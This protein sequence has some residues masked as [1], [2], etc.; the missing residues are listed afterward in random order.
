[1]SGHRELPVTIGAWW[2]T[3]MAH[4]NC[5]LQP[6]WAILGTNPTVGEWE[7]NWTGK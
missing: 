4:Q 6:T 3:G 7:G 1:M 2:A 5:L